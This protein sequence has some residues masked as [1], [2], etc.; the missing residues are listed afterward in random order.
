MLM[1]STSIDCYAQ[2]KFDGFLS[3]SLVSRFMPRLKL[4]NKIF[5]FENVCDFMILFKNA[6][7]HDFESV[8]VS[9]I[10]FYLYFSPLRLASAVIDGCD[11][12]DYWFVAVSVWLNVSLTYAFILLRQYSMDVNELCET[13]MMRMMM[14]SS[15]Y[16]CGERTKANKFLNWMA[17]VGKAENCTRRTL[18]CVFVSVNDVMIR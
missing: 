11:A 10:F 13:M 5:L 2:A 16:E 18:I 15:R 3:L 9:S 6:M 14:I 8:F 4:K 1:S 7:A 17:L 12:M